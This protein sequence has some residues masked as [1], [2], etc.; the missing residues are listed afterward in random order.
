M[1][2]NAYHKTVYNSQPVMLYEITMGD[3]TWRHTGAEVDLVVGAQ[4]YTNYP[5]I[6]HSEVSNSGEAAR[7]EVTIHLDS[8]HPLAQYLL[9]YVP[10]QEVFVTVSLLERADPDAQLV[11]EWSGV[12]LRHKFRAPEFSLICEPVDYEVNREAMQ[13]SFAPDC[14]WTQYDSNCGLSSATFQE[15][16]TVQSFTG[17]DVT[18]TADLT[19][20]AADH[21]QGGFVEI[22]GAYGKERG[23][24]LAQSGG[25]VS[26]DRQLP[27]LVA[28]MAIT[29]VPSCRGSFD[30]CK[31]PALFNNKIKFMGAPH[32]TG[33]NPYDGRSGVKGDQ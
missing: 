17:L 30:R 19:S 33:V 21:F 2:L 4:T 12:Y 3:T 9:A 31:N 10:T 27:S 16:G 24:I 26:L 15:A 11:H 13:P 32:A 6:G 23:L 8:L 1:T 5:G 25:T 22:A 29:C 7:N 20:I 28:G 18:T 14:Q